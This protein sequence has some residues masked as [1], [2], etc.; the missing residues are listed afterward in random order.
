M[1]KPKAIVMHSYDGLRIRIDEDKEYSYD[2][3]D[4]D[5][6]AAELAR[7]LSDLGFEVTVEEVY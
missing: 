4:E 5:Y 6:G 2:H 3:D 1:S 7:L